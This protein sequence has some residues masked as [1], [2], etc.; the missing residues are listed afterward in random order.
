LTGHLNFFVDAINLT[1][2]PLLHLVIEDN[3]IDDNDDDGIEIRL[4]SY[5]GETARCRISGN[6]ITR[7][8]EDGIQFI[9]YPDTSS[10]SYL[11][12]GNLICN[13]AMA[14]IGL[15]DNGVTREDYRG[16]PVPEPIV[17]VNNTILGHRYGLTG[18]AGINSVNNIIVGSEFSGIR[19]LTGKAVLSHCLFFR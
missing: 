1:N 4:H 13:N 7:N 9:D 15:M 14:G 19:N 10:R 16:A 17:L 11:V 6:R 2:A 18:G 8:G 12:E 3:I 5:S